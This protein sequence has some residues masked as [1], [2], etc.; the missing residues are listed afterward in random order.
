M[1]TA[2]H[3][4]KSLIKTVDNVDDAL[5]GIKAGARIMYDHTSGSIGIR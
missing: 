5:A 3:E 4:K 1:S 2:Q